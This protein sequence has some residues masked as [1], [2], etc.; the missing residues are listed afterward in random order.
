[1]K[2][3]KKIICSVMAV[4]IAVSAVAVSGVSASAAS[5]KAP[6]KVT[7]K[8]IKNGIQIKWSKVSGA[9]GYQVFRGSKK[10]ITFKGTSFTDASCKAGKTY[11][12]K[13]KALKGNTASKA[14]S[15][16]KV[17][18][19]FAALFST[20][21]N[22]KDGIKLTWNGRRGADKFYVYRKTTGN[23]SKI[24][25]STGRSYV[26]TNVV[27]GVNYTYKL[28]AKNT[29]TGS[30]SAFDANSIVRL[31]EVQ[32]VTARQN[33][34][35]DGITVNWASVKGAS[36]YA[37][38]RMKCTESTFKKIA[39]VNGTTYNDKSAAMPNPTAYSYQVVALKGSSSSSYTA[40]RLTGFV[41]KD[42]DANEN[43][44]YKDSEGNL[45][46]KL[47]F[48][49][50]DV[51]AEGKALAETLSLVNMYTEEITEGKDVVTLENSVITAKKAG[52]AVIEINANDAA[53]Q[54]ASSVNNGFVNGW[55]TNTVILE[56]TVS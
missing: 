40:T 14:T 25:T 24:K 9:T 31:D 26:D 49:V 28:V 8:N 46:I 19:L 48:K 11:T 39:T 16:K 34:S 41:P 36:S 15:S 21:S 42:A 18:R 55:V 29:K 4:L 37:V 38:Y 1:M 22:T 45:H 43:R 33:V 23:Y 47:K 20:L 6:K 3:S 30:V 27:S 44:Y 5:V 35:M 2:F 13:V 53:K 17:T 32:N 10:L 51:Y 12:Y 54:I 56:I 7:T 50:G 52:T